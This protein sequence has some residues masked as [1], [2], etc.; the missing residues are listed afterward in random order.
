MKDLEPVWLVQPEFSGAGIK[1]PLEFSKELPMKIEV[2][3]VEEENLLVLSPCLQARD[4]T[5]R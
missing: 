4:F 1:S 2:K 5:G 3:G